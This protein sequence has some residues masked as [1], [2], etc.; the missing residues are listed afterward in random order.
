[1]FSN[2][3][4]AIAP[5][6]GIMKVFC[7]HPVIHNGEWKNPGDM[8]DIDDK[9]FEHISE[10]CVVVQVNNDKDDKPKSQTKRRKSK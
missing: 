10:R 1:M 4:G 5:N 3:K 6:G 7:K 8:F 2:P 9:D